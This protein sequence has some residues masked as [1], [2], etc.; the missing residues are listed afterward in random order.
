MTRNLR[1]VLILGFGLFLTVPL[2]GHHGTN[3]SYDMMNPIALTGTVTQIVFSNPHC[4]LYFD[5]KD[6]SGKIINWGGELNSPS[7]LRNIG[8]SKNT[9]KIGDQVKLTVYPSRTGRPV[10]NVAEELSVFVNGKELPRRGERV[11]EP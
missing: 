2:L 10:G 4:Q 6:A 1:A 5:V 8:W 3:I 9:F 7:N 11:P